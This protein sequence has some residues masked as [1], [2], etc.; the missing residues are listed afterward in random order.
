MRRTRRK[1]EETRQDILSTAEDLFREKGIGRCSIA[2]IAN[3]LQ[4]SP[5]NVFKHFSSKTQ[6]ADAICDR[7]IN[8]MIDRFALLNDPAP[9]PEKLGIVVRK[10]MEAHL[11]DIRENPYL[12]EMIFLMSDADLPSGRHYKNLIDTLFGEVL[13]EGVAAGVYTC[14]DPEH[15]RSTVAAAFSG[16]LH[17]VFLIKT[18]PAELKER[19]EGLIDLVNAALQNPLAK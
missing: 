14:G 7:H 9:A 2:D 16:I 8:R 15:L 12:F 18:S 5:A 11:S 13:K 17:P 3:E 10:L 6:L 1:A 19:C 4:M